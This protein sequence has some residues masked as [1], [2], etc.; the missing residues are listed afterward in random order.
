MLHRGSRIHD[1]YEIWG[2]LGEGGMSEVWLAKHTVLCVPVII[3]T[4]RKAI[5][6]AAGEAGAKRMFN[7]AR[8]M[9]RVANPR[10]VRAIDAGIDDGTPYLVQEYVDGIDMAELDAQRR[11]AFGVGL[12]L[13]LVC[14]VMAETCEALHAA[15]QAGVIHRDVK[16]SNLFAAPES[17]IRLGDFGIAVARADAPSKEVSGTIKFMAPE[18]LRGGAVDRTTDVYGAGATA[19][20]LRYGRAPHASLDEVLDEGRMPAF[21]PP[22]FP[23]EAYF[24][25]LLHAMLAKDRAHRPQDLAEPAKHF[26]LLSR[27]LHGETHREGLVCPTRN[28]LRLGDCSIAMKVGDLSLEDAD[29][30]VSSAN[31]E[32]TMRSGSGNALRARG[33]DEI[34]AEAMSGG[35]RALGMCVV[36]GAGT[37]RAKHVLHAVSAW[38]ETSCIG[39][40][41]FRALL[42]AEQ[43]GLKTLAMPALG[44]GS[45]RV[46]LETCAS[47]MMTAL[48]WHLSL[49]GSRLH[50]VTLVLGDEAKLKT[51]RDVAEEAL[52]GRSADA[53][54]HSTDLGLQVEGGAVQEDAATFLDPASRG[55]AT[56]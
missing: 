20:D 24:Q 11:R 48:R 31:Y 3:K 41:M 16:P 22:Q 17:G 46:S 6:D 44:T 33:G 51:Y 15:H 27:A 49:G 10:V 14:L 12:P 32:M 37:L 18:Q 42:L 54:P 19:F 28:E 2:R 13:W 47:A 1:D 4:L 36:T 26:A 25:H 39:R 21:P 5:A 29:A 50:R 23:A 40:A 9:A 35:E 43:L 52:R 53:V 45:S 34:E 56:H 7:E 38:N 55:S 8:L 30:F